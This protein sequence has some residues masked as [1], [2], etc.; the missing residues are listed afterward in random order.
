MKTSGY[1]LKLLAGLLLSA[2][3]AWGQVQLFGD[4]IQVVALSCSAKA[5]QVTGSLAPIGASVTAPACFGFGKATATAQAWVGPPELTGKSVTTASKNG[6]NAISN[7]SSHDLAILTPPSGRTGSVNVELV[8]DYTSNVTNSSKTSPGSFWLTWF[9]ANTKLYYV[10]SSENGKNTVNVSIPFTLQPSSIGSYDFEVTLAGGV[11]A[12][13]GPALNS[14]PPSASLT[15]GL[16]R[17]RLPPNWTCTWQS[18]GTS[19]L[20]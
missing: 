3:A 19:C 10:S 6:D 2:S 8:T 12:N 5:K 11:S 17:F 16:I 1:A 4:L 20:E 14:A 7:V 15:T 9:Q 18:T 13:S